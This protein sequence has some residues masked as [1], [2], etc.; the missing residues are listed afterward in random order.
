MQ[1]G[2]KEKMYDST[3]HCWRKI[4]ATEGLNAF[5]KGAFSN[6]LRGTGG[7]FV[8]VLYDEIKALLQMSQINQRSSVHPEP[9]PDIISDRIKTLGSILFFYYK[10]DIS[11]Y[12][13]P[14]D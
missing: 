11:P 12:G 1:S 5:F 2:L 6:V 13:I 9:G 3:M 4:Y 10:A 7:A 14:S 8:L